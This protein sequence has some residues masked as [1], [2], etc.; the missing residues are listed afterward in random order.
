MEF[1]YGKDV[2]IEF[3]KDKLEWDKDNHWKKVSWKIGKNAKQR[4][5]QCPICGSKSAKKF[6]GWYGY[7]YMRCSRCDLIYANRR[8]THEESLTFYSEDKDYDADY[9]YT[10]KKYLKERERIFKPKADF[11]KKYV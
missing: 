6:F 4:I 10:S 11:I 3:L 1:R 5:K 9:I 7:S 8:L 2:S